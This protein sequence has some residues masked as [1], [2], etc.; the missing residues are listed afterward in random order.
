MFKQ[1]NNKII[2]NLLSAIHNDLV[3]MKI[4]NQNKSRTKKEKQIAEQLK[5]FRD[6]LL[7]DACS[8]VGYIHEGKFYKNLMDLG[9]STNIEN[10]EIEEISIDRVISVDYLLHY[11]EQILGL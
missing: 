2:I 10:D 3:E 1:Q 8:G 11:I 5:G 6:S 7:L 9:N 4:D